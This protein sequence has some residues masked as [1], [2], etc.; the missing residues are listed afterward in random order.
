M[1]NFFIRT[2]TALALTGLAAPALAAPSLQERLANPPANAFEHGTL[3]VLRA[4]ET[5]LQS[6]YEYGLGD[7]FSR[8][9]VIR[10]PL[11]GGPNPS[12][13]QA[14][15]DTLSHII[16]TLLSD[17]NAARATLATASPEPFNMP[18]ADIWLDSN[19]NGTQDRGESV[20]ELLGESLMGRR[21]MRVFSSDNVVFN[22]PTIRFDEADHAWLTAYTHM[23]SGALNTYR[24]YDPAP[25]MADLAEARAALQNVPELPEYY[26]LDAIRA[27]LETLRPQYKEAQDKA[28]ETSSEQRAAFDALNQ[29]REDI[30]KVEASDAADKDARLLM[31]TEEQSLLEKT[32]DIALEKF[33]VANT[34]QNTL[35]AEIRSLEQQLPETRRRG[36]DPGEFSTQ[37]DTVYILLTALAQQPD[38]ARIKTAV[39][40]WRHMIAQN[41]I[42]WAQVEEETDNENEWIPNSRQTSALPFEVTPD[43]VETWQTILAE[44]E[45]LLD[46]TLLVPH[47]LLPEGHGLSLKLF[48]EDPSPLEL[49]GTVHGRS[50]YRYVVKGPT[51]SGINWSR[52]ARLTGGN[53]GGFALWFN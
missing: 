44:G 40:H 48:I 8:T 17:L 47:P 4:V 31:L 9:P 15:P 14:A 1:F 13:K 42:F 25:V 29:L 43:M 28:A 7:S 11:P 2:V 20:V 22:P 24:A 41:R 36:F 23:I 18:L 5:S 6:R 39:A 35:R 26:D 51:M 45:A 50:L 19:M 53:A 3:Q 38:P 49:V 52:F 12:P 46:G 27:K 16:D 21:A 10:L 37:I 30:K 34:L 32:R 33:R